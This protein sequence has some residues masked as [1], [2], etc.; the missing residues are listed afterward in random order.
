M[1]KAAAQ[2]LRNLVGDRMVAPRS[3]KRAAA[4]AQPGAAA[5]GVSAPKPA[6]VAAVAP[7]AAAPV[8]A[9]V[10]PARAA[11]PANIP[12]KPVAPVRPT[13]PLPGLPAFALPVAADDVRLRE[14]KTMVEQVLQGRRGDPGPGIAKL[15]A[16]LPSIERGRLTREQKITLLADEAFRASS[17]TRCGLCKSRTQVVYADGDPD[18]EVLFVGEGPGA[19]ED[20]QGVPFVG[21]AGRRLT[22]IIEKGMK[23]PRSA[24]YICNI[25]KCRPPENRVPEADEAANCRMWLEKQIEIVAPRV[26]MLLGAT[27][28]KGI[29]GHTGSMGSVHG[30]FFKYRG[31]P[32]L[33][34]YHPSWLIRMETPEKKRIIWEDFKQVIGYLNGSIPGPA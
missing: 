11:A 6:A 12:M 8:A 26:I 9:A 27:A 34:T 29:L 22:D 18:A 1:R 28:L 3:A 31:I 25:V 23:V 15:F 33:P 16:A 5:A 7:R 32:V 21:R 13:G 14:G 10:A 4:A 17:C 2:R 19:D 30:K 24:V 20:A